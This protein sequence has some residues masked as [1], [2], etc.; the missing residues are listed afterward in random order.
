MAALNEFSLSFSHAT[1]VLDGKIYQAIDS[2]SVD[3]SLQESAV[4]GT[5]V[6]P[7]GR[8]TGVLDMGTG[9]LTFSDIAEGVDFWRALGPQ[10]LMRIFAIDYTLSS[11]SGSV[12]TF[13]VQ[14]ARLTG[15]GIEHSAGPDALKISYPFSF[16]RLAAEGTELAVDAQKILRAGLG[17]AQNLT[18]LL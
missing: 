11:E 1:I 15:I 9:S 6:A 10:S 2:I 17:I 7:L 4:R 13:R 18:S 5:S 8:S 16:L 3:Q 12:R 14:G